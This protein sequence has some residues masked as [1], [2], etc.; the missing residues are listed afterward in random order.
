[1]EDAVWL[2]DLDGITNYFAEIV[3]NRTT[4]EATR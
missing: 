3:R 4:A 2:A 1:M